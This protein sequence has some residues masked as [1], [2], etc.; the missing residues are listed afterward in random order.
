HAELF[1][2]NLLHA[3]FDAGHSDY[4]SAI[5]DLGPWAARQ[6]SRARF[7]LPILCGTLRGVNLPIGFR[8]C[9]MPRGATSPETSVLR[10]DTV[11]RR[12]R[13]RAPRHRIESRA[14]N[15]VCAPPADPGKRLGELSSAPAALAPLSARLRS[16][17]AR[18]PA[19]G[20]WRP[21]TR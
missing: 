1:D 14:R 3:F 19:C 11:R 2:N 9:Y 13:L 4:S 17:P 16:M 12:S 8:A 5:G 15:K 10:Q 21:Q 18:F 7:D 6:G 20:R